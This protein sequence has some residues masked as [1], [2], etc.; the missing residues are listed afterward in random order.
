[1]KTKRFF[2]FCKMKSGKSIFFFIHFNRMSIP[3]PPPLPVFLE[4]KKRDDSQP[5]ASVAAEVA[6][7][8][9]ERL[10][11]RELL[12]TETPPFFS[13]EGF[14]TKAKC[15]R[16]TATGMHLIFSLPLDENLYSWKCSTPALTSVEEIEGKILE[17]QCGAFDEDGN[18]TVRL[19][20]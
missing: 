4:E 13:L 19:L 6:R 3:T 20:L 7:I 8:A 5:I 17:I 14:Q 10:K 11:R 18:L 2:V 9:K 1:M 12:H 16:A 15:V